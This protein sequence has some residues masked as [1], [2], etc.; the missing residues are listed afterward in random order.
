MTWLLVSSSGARRVSCVVGARKRESEA[1]YAAVVVAVVL[2]A[3]G[4]VV[5]Q[6]P[7]EALVAVQRSSAVKARTGMLLLAGPGPSTTRSMGTEQALV[8][9]AGKGCSGIGMADS[10]RL[11]QVSVVRV[12]I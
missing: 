4:L 3:A 7:V 8:V 11:L 10:Q 6:L 1:A 5:G 12:N 2:L 9:A